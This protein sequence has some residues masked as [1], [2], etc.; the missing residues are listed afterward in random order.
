MNSLRKDDSIE[1]QQPT[2]KCHL[3]LTPFAN[4]MWGL[5]HLPPWRSKWHKKHWQCLLQDWSDLLIVY[6]IKG[7]IADYFEVVNERLLKVAINL[8]VQKQIDL[9]FMFKQQYWVF[10]HSI[11]YKV[12]NVLYPLDHTRRLWSHTQG[13]DL[14]LKAMIS[15]SKAMISQLCNLIIHNIEVYF[16]FP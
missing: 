6:N 1:W 14:T 2:S 12:S 8:L 5:I 7:H 4:S 16:F 15:H 3:L 11:W 10:K 13:Y 9:E